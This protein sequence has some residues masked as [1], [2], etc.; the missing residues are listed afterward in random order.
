MR[1]SLS[2]HVRV[3]CVRIRMRVG[4]LRACLYVRVCCFVWSI[5]CRSRSWLPGREV[6]AMCLCAVRIPSS[7]TPSLSLRNLPRRVEIQAWQMICWIPENDDNCAS[8]TE[9]GMPPL[10]QLNA[11]LVA[12]MRSGRGGAAVVGSGPNARLSHAL[13]TASSGLEVSLFV[14]NSS[15]PSCSH[16]FPPTAV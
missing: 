12:C 4:G 7:A 1:L 5:L 11:P 9:D 3:C 15:P 10:H 13:L 6:T 16:P 2:L 8:L 14:K